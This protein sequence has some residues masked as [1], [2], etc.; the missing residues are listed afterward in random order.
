M[1]ENT[2]QP[3]PRLKLYL[4]GGLVVLFFLAAAAATR[5]GITW[6]EPTYVGAGYGYVSWFVRL[7]ARSFDAEGIDSYWR[8]NAEHPPAAKLVYGL[9][10]ALEGG[11]T[12]PG[13]MTARFFAAAL[14]VLLAG[15][16]YVLAARAGGRPAGAFAA[17][18]LVL[19]PR[20]FGHGHLAALDLPVALACLA[21]TLAFAGAEKSVWRAVG[22]GELW[23]VALL[24][25]VNAVFL[26]VVLIPWA[27]WAHRK[28]GLRPCALLLLVGGL[29]FFAGWPWLWH[30]TGERVGA[31]IGNKVERLGD[32]DGATGTTQVPV[33]YLGTTYRD[34]SAP[35]HYPFVLTLA[36]VPLG[37]LV[38]AG[39]GCR[40]ARPREA[41]G[42]LV[43]LILASGLLHLVV[44]ALPKVP[45][46]DGVRLF[47]PAFPF[48][49]CLAG[50]GAAR[51]WAWRGRLGEVLVAA[52]LVLN[53]AAL[54]HSTPYELSYYNC[55]VG[56]ARGARA[57]GFETTYWG[58]TVNRDVIAFVN[59]ACPDGSSLV[60]WPPYQAY[61]DHFPGVRDGIRYWRKWR[62]G[63]EEPD[64][65][66][67][68]P[69]QG[70]LGEFARSLAGSGPPARQWT[71]LGVPQCLV[72]DL[73]NRSAGRVSGPR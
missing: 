14:F 67:L 21:T 54:V 31:Y 48:I 24:T 42:R 66:V 35:W 1:S 6:D 49:A 45:K 3:D 17:L 65:V 23:G 9:A 60:V 27:L 15:L 55:L 40:C 50:L 47:L 39:L 62:P 72:Y 70:Y 20:V 41:H 52:V 22:A 73:R 4:A 51:V 69:R 8:P 32:G 28:R 38:F 25:K 46:Y 30:R 34:R 53:G 37:L 58:D 59:Q 44:V 43:I 5:P 68:F 57:L 12:L 16:V 13:L 63:Q 64:F 36:T 71:Y 18:A 19:M 61:F 33:H 11:R 29:T 2:S 26:P 7:S 10:G 56:G